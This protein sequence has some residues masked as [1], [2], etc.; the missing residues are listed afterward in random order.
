MDV[1]KICT[2]CGQI[3][4]LREFIDFKA[5]NTTKQYR[6]CNNCRTKNT[7]RRKNIKNTKKRP[8]EN[9]E[10]EEN[11]LNFCDNNYSRYDEEI[12]FSETE[13]DTNSLEVVEVADFFDYIA[14]LL[15]IYTTQIE[16]K[17]NIP[18]FHFECKVDISTLNSSVKEVV[19]F[20]IELIEEADEFSW[21]YVYSINIKLC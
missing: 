7:K 13:K 9:E 18:P 10:F 1:T 2:A 21:M 14:Q 20:L 16:N 3:K 19:D 11:S 5:K 17:E 12:D 4:L 15:N 6:T 8:Y